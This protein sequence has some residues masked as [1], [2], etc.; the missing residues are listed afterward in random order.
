MTNRDEFSASVKKKLASRAGYVCSFPACDELT[1]GPASNEQGTV[2]TGEAAHITAASP[3][4]PR[5]DPMMSPIERKSVSNGIWMC[6]KHARVIDVDK[7]Q[8]TVPELKKW[9]ES[10]ETKIKYQQQGIKIN[11]GFLTK[12][13]ISN[14]ARIHGEENV[15]LGKNTLLFGNMSTGKSIIC[16]L[17]AGLEKNQLLWRWKQKRNVGNTYAEIEIFDGEITSFM[18]NVYEKQIR[19]YVN[20]NEYPLINPTYSVVY[21]NETFRYNSEA[22]KP[23]IEQY[24]DYFNLTVNDMLNV[25]NLK[26]DIGIKLVSDYYFKDNDLLVREYPSQ[27]NALDYKALSS[28]E[29]QRINIEIGSKVA[30]VLSNSKPTILIIEHDSFSSFDKSNRETLFTTINN[31]KLPY[32]TLLTVYSYDDTIEMNNFN[33]YEHKEINGTVKIMKNNSND[34]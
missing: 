24:A 12:I 10:H 6:K 5:Y 15:D 32:Q 9:K 7:T 14:I 2:M 27:T 4:G 28:S 22:S 3:N 34:I 30:H 25:I 26:G 19:Y 16:E 13:K 23:F 33:I 31:S 11:K 21:L 18:V 1:I 29:K 20:S 8:Y 17:I